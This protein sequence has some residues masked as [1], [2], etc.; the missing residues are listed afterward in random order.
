M[1]VS[2]A[3]GDAHLTQISTFMVTVFLLQ[4]GTG[5]NE[6]TWRLLTEER[7]GDTHQSRYFREQQDVRN[8]GDVGQ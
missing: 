2:Q 7:T 8:I 5:G 1:R 4:K 3:T 6:D